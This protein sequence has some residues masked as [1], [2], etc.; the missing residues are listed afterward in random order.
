MR[1]ALLQAQKVLGNTKTNPA[2]GCVLVKNQNVI[3]AGSTGINGRPHAESEAIKYS[4]SP[5][6]IINGL[7]NRAT[8]NFSG[9][10]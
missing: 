10:S 3:S 9:Q 1:L 2:V 7:P 5:M 8:T 6:P 4:F